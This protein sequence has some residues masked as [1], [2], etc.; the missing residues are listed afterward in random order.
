[1]AA[2]AG[3]M[4][5]LACKHEEQHRQVEVEETKS[6]YIYSGGES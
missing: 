3:A 6:T 1:M 5:V 4:K 2:G